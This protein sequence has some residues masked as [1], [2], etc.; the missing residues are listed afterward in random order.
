MSKTTESQIVFNE[1]RQCLFMTTGLYCRPED[2]GCNAYKNRQ[3]SNCL[4]KSSRDVILNKSPNI[5]EIKPDNG[6]NNAIQKNN[7]N[8]HIL[9]IVAYSILRKR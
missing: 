5:L 8:L 2:Y 6:Q 7:L 1:T 4:S 9:A 3:F